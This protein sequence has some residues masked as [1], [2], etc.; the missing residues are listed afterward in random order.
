MHFNNETSN[1]VKEVLE[2]LVSE[3]PRK[4]VRIW[5]GDVKTGLAWNDEYD[6]MGYIGRST[7]EQKIPLLVNNARSFGGGGIL[8]HCIVR[9]DDIAAKTTLYKHP[10]FKCDIVLSNVDNLLVLPVS[11]RFKTPDQAQRF[12]KFMHGERYSK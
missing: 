9:I 6:I 2:K 8:T 4:R 3:T 10:N 5:Y 7:G 11:A 12:I 1:E